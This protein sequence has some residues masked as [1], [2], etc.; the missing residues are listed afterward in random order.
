M[1]LLLLCPLAAAALWAQG[2][3]V[4]QGCFLQHMAGD[5]P[6]PAAPSRPIPAE[7]R[8]RGDLTWFEASG[9]PPLPGVVCVKFC[10]LALSQPTFG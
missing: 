7:L 6:A 9:M 1:R 8:H 2:G 4:F 3:I 5:V 10:K